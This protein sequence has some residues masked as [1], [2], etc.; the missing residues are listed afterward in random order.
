MK[1]II[2]NRPV[3]TILILYIFLIIILNFC[4]YFLP[5]KNSFLLQLIKDEQVELTG[6]VI[7]SPTHK[8]NKQQ[9]ILEV[10]DVNNTKIK[11]EKTLV[12][13]SGIYNVKYGDII[14]GSGKLNIAQKPTFP[15]NF[16]YNLYLQRDNIYT[17]FYQ[18]NFEFVK[19]KTNI[20]KYLSLKT[21]DNIENK[22]DQ[23][24]KEPYSSIIKSNGCLR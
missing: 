14:C 24:F 19:Q 5:Q 20:I 13:L 17:I 1:K 12:Y 11:K 18:Q 7:T 15:Y 22:T 2:F 21:R 3:I 23:Y 16:D 8:D 4:G 6:K 10:Y 9:F